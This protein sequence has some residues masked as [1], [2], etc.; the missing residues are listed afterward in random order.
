MLPGSGCAGFECHPFS[1]D[2]GGAGG[3]L[4]FVSD[5]TARDAFEALPLPNVWSKMSESYPYV[6]EV[7]M[8]ILLM[9]PSTL[10]SANKDSRQCSACKLN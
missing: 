3:L 10:F 9:F 6:A 8:G 5:S 1:A 2:T 4:K 7:P